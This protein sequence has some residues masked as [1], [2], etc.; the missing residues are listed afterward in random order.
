MK[1]LESH[2]FEISEMAAL[3]F[4]A[5]AIIN[6]ILYSI[7][8]GSKRDRADKYK[9]AYSNESTAWR[10]TAILIA[11]AA[12][13]MGFNVISG[14][15]GI[16]KTYMFVFVGFM[17]FMLSFVIGYAF[18]AFLKYYYPNVLEKKLKNIRFA[19]FKS[20]KSGKP[21]RLLNELEEDE[22]L[23]PEMVEK[24]DNLEAD[25]DVWIDDDSGETVIKQYDILE[26]ALVC[27]S[28][29]FRTLKETSEN[30]IQE[31]TGTEA[32]KAERMYKCSYCG[33]AEIK[34]VKL[35]SW[36]EKHGAA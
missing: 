12:F 34:E 18:W 20:P 13:F 10:R 6:Q 26:K 17:S 8:L 35:P 36:A 30:I 16:A 33:H 7:Q 25:F 3:A 29:N 2:W 21:M 4:L 27:P 14:W 24:E 19:Q 11:A 31:P 9:F 1:T 23:T 28:C 32:G 5:F 15:L 22:F